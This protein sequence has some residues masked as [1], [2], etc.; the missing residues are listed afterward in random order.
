MVAWC[1]LRVS[2][3]DLL[4]LEKT[5]GHSSETRGELDSQSLTEHAAEETD[6]VQYKAEVCAEQRRGLARGGTL[7][8]GKKRRCR[9]SLKTSERTSAKSGTFT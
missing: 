9:L 2:L 8:G 3:T 4:G 7:K 5:S 6:P 1:S